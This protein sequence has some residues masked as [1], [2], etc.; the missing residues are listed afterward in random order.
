MSKKAGAEERVIHHF[1]CGKRF[2]LSQ[3]VMNFLSSDRPFPA[4]LIRSSWHEGGNVKSEVG[5]ARKV[6]FKRAPRRVLWVSLD[7]YRAKVEPTGVT[8]KG[9]TIISS[10]LADHKGKSVT[11]NWNALGEAKGHRAVPWRQTLAD[12]KGYELGKDSDM[13]VVAAETAF[14][15][16]LDDFLAI[17]LKL[18]P[19]TIRWIQ[20]RT[21]EE[22]ASVWYGEAMGQSLPT[23]FRQEY[24]QWQRHAKELRDSIVHRRSRTNLRQ[25]R[26][27]FR[28]VLGLISKIDPKWFLSFAVDEKTSLRPGRLVGVTPPDGVKNM[29][30]EVNEGKRRPRKEIQIWV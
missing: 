8:K 1:R 21:I 18:R 29:I 4:Y 28:A 15:L 11:T 6:R 10:K 25:G 19:N 20:K 12:S 26:A 9:F 13:Q 16:F 3:G 2:S 30:R 14:E 5:Q 17:H 22:K 27:A 23:Q 24:S 7:A